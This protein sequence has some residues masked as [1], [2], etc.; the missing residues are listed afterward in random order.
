MQ[1]IANFTLT[2]HEGPYN[3]WPLKSPLLFN[4]EATNTEVLGS[5]IVAQYLCCYGYLL[6]TSYGADY[7]ESNEFQLLNSEFK[8]IAT[9]RLGQPY[10]SFLLQSHRAISEDCLQLQYGDQLYYTLSIK[11]P[12]GWLK[13][14]FSLEIKQS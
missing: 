3:Q 11:A 8:P 14:K 9:K 1:Q 7:E 12:S 6:I 4:T 13:R 10:S 5:Q 2:K